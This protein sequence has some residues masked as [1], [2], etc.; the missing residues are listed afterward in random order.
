MRFLR[1][2]PFFRPRRRNTGI[3]PIEGERT[4]LPA[5]EIVLGLSLAVL[6]ALAF[7][8]G[9]ILTLAAA[10]FSVGLTIG[11]TLQ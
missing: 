1:G 10:M 6:V 5:F 2:L 7:T 4:P 8:G 9:G 3:V 11:K